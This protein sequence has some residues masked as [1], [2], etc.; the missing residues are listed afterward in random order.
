MT[1]GLRRSNGQAQLV[2]AWK[3]SSLG[4]GVQSSRKMAGDDRQVRS[5]NQP[6]DSGSK[7]PHFASP[8]ACA[9]RKNDQ[10]ISIIGQ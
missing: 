1:K 10:D 6:T 3:D 4:P 8:G 5:Y 9:F 7:V 2:G